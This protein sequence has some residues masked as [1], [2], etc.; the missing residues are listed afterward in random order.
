MS[1]WVQQSALITVE[2]LS[3][4]LNSIVLAKSECGGLNFHVLGSKSHALPNAL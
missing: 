4:L 1:L 2:E 3:K